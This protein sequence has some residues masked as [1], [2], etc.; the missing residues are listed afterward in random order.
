MVGERCTLTLQHLVAAGG[1][2]ILIMLQYVSTG[3]AKDFLS[4][5]AVKGVLS[6]DPNVLLLI[7]WN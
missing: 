2:Q 3:A 4:E 7:I 6:E 5:I 1:L